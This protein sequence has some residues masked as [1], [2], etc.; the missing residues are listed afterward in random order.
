MNSNN[1]DYLDQYIYTYIDELT[2][3]S[4]KYKELSENL[5]E[6]LTDLFESI[7]EED[8][9]EI[10]NDIDDLNNYLITLNSLST[11][12]FITIK[13]NGIKL[14][15]KYSRH[16]EKISSLKSNNSLLQEELAA[17]NE[18]KDKA[19]SKIDELNDEY[20]KLY[21]EKNNLEV[22]NALKMKEDEEKF[23]LNYEI[24]TD[25]IKSL[26]NKMESLKKQINSK[27]EKI[28]D[29]TSKNIEYMEN[30][31]LMK[32]ELKFKDEIIQSW[33]DKNE[34]IKEENE[35]IRFM[36]S[37]LQKTIEI[38]DNQ[39]KDYE[40]SIQQLKEQINYYDKISYSKN[41]TGNM[42][43][44]SFFND[45]EEKSN[46]GDESGIGTNAKR[47]NGVD[48][49][50]MGINLNDLLFDQSENSENE[51]ISKKTSQFKLDLSKI[52]NGVKSP[53]YK[54]RK[55]S[56]ESEKFKTPR[57]NYLNKGFENIIKTKLLQLQ[58]Y[59]NENGKKVINKNDEAFLSEL[60]FRLLDC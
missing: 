55:S 9:K 40:K 60:L 34:K 49:T 11:K 30:K 17:A 15:E 16:K 31:E 37:G 21:Q 39:C 57:K 38:L 25:E 53:N 2:K 24:F 54:Y 56:E 47:R 41:P 52:K 22:K 7:E 35:N 33:I 29:L 1:K 44:L 27:E 18:Q 26:N 43:N 59:K 3:S 48:Y 20:D 46:Y 45:E 28:K 50:G 36:N 12:E 14:I 51:Q 8:C 4:E 23:K 10:I 42:N 32:K 6:R 19:L 13:N 58:N 5:K